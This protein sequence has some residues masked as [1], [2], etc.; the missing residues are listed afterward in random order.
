MS[1]L[2]PFDNNEISAVLRIA[3]KLFTNDIKG[4]YTIDICFQVARNFVAHGIFVQK[5]LD[6]GHYMYSPDGTCVGY[7]DSTDDGK[8]LYAGDR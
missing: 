1:K 2:R 7:I 3:E 5:R 6:S 8:A 4:E